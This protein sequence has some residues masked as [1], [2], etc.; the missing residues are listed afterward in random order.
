MKIVWS[1]H[2]HRILRAQQYS[3]DQS[4][5]PTDIA[6]FKAIKGDDKL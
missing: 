5:N 4:L 2:G 1:W 6:F 3:N